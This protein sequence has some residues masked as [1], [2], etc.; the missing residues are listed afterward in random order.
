MIHQRS[1]ESLLVNAAAHNVILAIE[2]TQVLVHLCFGR[3]TGESRLQRNSNDY[4]RQT[5][6]RLWL[7]SQVGE[8]EALHFRNALGRKNL[9]SA[10]V[11]GSHDFSSLE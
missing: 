1:V 2:E 4:V 6:F 5:A 3:R 11:M 8:V 10:K 9:A 7:H